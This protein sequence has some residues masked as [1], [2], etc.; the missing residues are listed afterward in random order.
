MTV[1]SSCCLFSPFPIFSLPQFLCLKNT[2]TNIERA[3]IQSNSLVFKDNIKCHLILIA[4]HKMPSHALLHAPASQTCKKVL[5]D[6]MRW[7][8]EDVCPPQGHA[9]RGRHKRFKRLVFQH[10]AWNI[11]PYHL[12][13]SPLR[14]GIVQRSLCL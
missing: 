7:L 8:W 4:C 14:P 1:T 6:E 9:A 10:Q 2:I 11:F 13:F 5:M 3:F 12:L